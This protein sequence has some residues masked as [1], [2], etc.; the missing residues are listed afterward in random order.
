MSLHVRKDAWIGE[1]VWVDQPGLGI[2]SRCRGHAGN[3]QHYRM[4]GLVSPW[5]RISGT[6]PSDLPS[7]RSQ[8]SRK[9]LT[10]L[11]CQATKDG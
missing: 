1:M 7:L 2:Q 10:D 11:L 6:A 4:W 8:H 5:K 3:Q 9:L